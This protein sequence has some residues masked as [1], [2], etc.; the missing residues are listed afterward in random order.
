MG[1]GNALHSLSNNMLCNQ[2]GYMV[3]K[4]SY[5]NILSS[6]VVRLFISINLLKLKI[7]YYAEP[8]RKEEFTL[9]YEHQERVYQRFLTVLKTIPSV[10]SSFD[11]KVLNVK[12]ISSIKAVIEPSLYA[13]L[14][15]NVL[16]ISLGSTDKLYRGV[17][18]RC[19]NVD[20]WSFTIQLSVDEN[21][22]ID[23]AKSIEIINEKYNDYISE[24]CN[25]P[26]NAKAVIVAKKMDTQDTRVILGF[27]TNTKIIFSELRK[28]ASTFKKN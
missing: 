26:C 16:S 27:S 21:K 12:L 6:H 22:R 9:K 11:G 2:S 17:N 3:D 24:V 19:N 20:V 5:Q 28:F 10:I 8:K 13:S 18:G 4:I 14:N 23:A 25:T 15:G 7:M 1:V